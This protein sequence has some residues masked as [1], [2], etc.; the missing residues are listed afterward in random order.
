MVNL[1]EQSSTP[2]EKRLYDP[3]WWSRTIAIGRPLSFRYGEL[4]L[5]ELLI[6]DELSNEYP[7][8]RFNLRKQRGRGTGYLLTI[9]PGKDMEREEVKGEP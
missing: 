5:E 9:L 8:L 6:L 1:S 4:P 7:G 2:E 3:D